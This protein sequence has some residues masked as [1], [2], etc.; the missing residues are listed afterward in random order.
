VPKPQPAAPKSETADSIVY[1]GRV[2]GPDG[3]PVAGAK[4]YL[5]TN[6][7]RENPD[8]T[9][10]ATTGEDGRFRLTMAPAD[11]ERAGFIV[12]LAKG[13]GPDWIA[14]TRITDGEV[15]LRLAEDDIP[16]TGRILNLEG[17]PA[18]GATVEAVRL[19]KR[20]N[21]EG[22]TSWIE[23]NVQVRKQGRYLNEEGLETL[24]ADILDRP[25]AVTTDAEGRFRLAGFGRERVVRLQIGGPTIELVHVWAMTRPGPAGKFIDGHFGLYG[26]SFDYLASP[27]KPFVGTVRD[28]RTSQPLAG[29]VIE[30]A[31]SGMARTTTDSNGRY[32]LIG[33]PKQQ[34]GYWLSAGGGKGL[35]YFDLTKNRIADTPGLEP[36]TVDFELERGIEVT[37]CLTAKDTGKPVQGRVQYFPL[38]ENP[39]LKVFEAFNL[40]TVLVS[41]WGR[42]G[43]DGTFTVLVIPGPGV[44]TVHAAE[45]DRFVLVDARTELQKR[46]VNRFPADPVHALVR[47]NPSENDPKSL[48]YDIALEPGRTLNGSVVGPDGKPLAG[49]QVAGLSASDSVR[50]LETET[51][52]LKGLA[53][54]QKRVLVFFHQEKKLGKVQVVRGDEAGPLTVRLEPLGALTG[55]IVDA[56]GRPWAGLTVAV[57]PSLNE[58]DYEN[59]PRDELF[60][61]QGVMGL[62]PGLWRQFTGRQTTTDRDGRFRLEGLFPGWPYQLFAGKGDLKKEN[63]L[64]LSKDGLSAESGKAKDLGDLKSEH[65]SDE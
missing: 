23:Q 60:V 45:K 47:I 44:L 25:T 24:R 56:D 33:V 5:W 7:S 52:P 32:R 13:Y 49:V 8:R 62:G 11:R 20:P 41:D 63:A 57:Y 35:P 55:R 12:A 28:K 16:I 40:A 58:K 30:G 3:R 18:T 54:G 6:T 38:P 14:L 34:R 53:S 46:K 48:N 42:A 19:G 26:A 1:R 10:R 43:P 9:V 65:V 59:L 51:F 37:G 50:K 15:T 21:H 17:Q 61:F 31:P 64:V 39:N 2:L 29:I 36:L 22:L 4:L 27:T